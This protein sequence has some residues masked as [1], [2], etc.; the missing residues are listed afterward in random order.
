MIADKQDMFIRHYYDAS[1]S[2]VL[3]LTKGMA[4][5]YAR[6][7]ITVNAIGPALFE[8]EMTEGTLFK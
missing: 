7:G 2:A 1:K 4:C 5:S 8:S 6:Y 3:G